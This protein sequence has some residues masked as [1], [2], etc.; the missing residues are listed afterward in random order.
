MLFSKKYSDKQDLYSAFYSQ[1]S[2]LI[3]TR[4][5]LFIWYQEAE[6]FVREMRKL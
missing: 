1:C 4:R 2:S 3:E 6:A 5:C